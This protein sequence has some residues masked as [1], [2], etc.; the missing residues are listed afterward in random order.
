MK[1][2]GAIAVELAFEPGLSPDRRTARTVAALCAAHPGP[3]PVFV[4]WSDGNGVT[5]RLRA[6]RLRVALDDALLEELRRVLGP[7]RVHLVRAR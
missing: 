1:P 3:A 7:D 5:A 4:R 6:Q 2:A